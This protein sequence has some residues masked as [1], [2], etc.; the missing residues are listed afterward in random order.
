MNA[1]LQTP[2]STRVMN[3]A[4]WSTHNA[5]RLPE[6][7]ALVWGDKSWT[8]A[9]FDARVSAFAAALAEQ[10]VGPGSTVLVHSKNSNEMFESM[11]ATFR[12]GAT[13]VPTNFRLMPDEVVY[14][15]SKAKSQI[16]LCQSDFP[17]YA[18]A[19]C[20]ARPGTQVIWLTGAE[21]PSDDRPQA[22]ELIAARLGSTVPNAAVDRD[23]ACWFLFTS[24]TTGKPK[25]AVL[26]HGQMAFVVNNHLCRPAAW[27]GLQRRLAGSGAAVARR[28]RASADYGLAGRKDRAAAVGEVLR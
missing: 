10:G 7:I 17:E 8:W 22:S 24:G 2:T 26:T 28:R 14:I 6:Q 9:E 23:A 5:R 18:A 27:H 11:F 13:W 20:A 16:F 3:L 15:A 12:L 21:P 1:V 25:A 19:V 4:Y